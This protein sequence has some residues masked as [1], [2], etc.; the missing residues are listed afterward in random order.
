[1][2][3][4]KNQYLLNY[5]KNV[6]SQFGE[7]GIIEQIFSTIGIKHGICCEFG[8][9]DGRHLSNTYNL[10]ANKG[11]SAVLIEGNKSR[12]P[13][14]QKTFEE[15]PKVVAVNKYVGFSG[16]DLLDNILSSHNVPKNIDFLSIDIDG[17]D[18]HI[19]DS[20]Q[21]YTPK[22]VVIEFNPFIP[23]DVEFVQKRDPNVQHGTSILSM[24]KLAL[25]KGY[26]LICINQENAFYVQKKYFGRFKI[27]DNSIQE[28]KHYKE[29]LKVFQLYDG[30]LVFQGAQYL[31]YY[32]F[33]YDFN[34][35]FQVLPEVIRRDNLPWGG[36]GITS[37][38]LY[39]VLK[40]LKMRHDEKPED[41]WAWKT[42]YDNFNTR[43]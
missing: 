4:S 43:I 12:F 11:W 6:E 30:T 15:N 5:R 36:R 21:L 33:A 23:A 32:N 20:L 29:P 1:M 14:L 17:N 42:V 7:D 25:K 9:W 34:K 37:K 16:D 18:Y 24:T 41:C 13:Q 19:W 27:K 35:H 39:K 8:A 40:F 26:Q 31:Y 22:V 2:A 38:I 3:L 28:L 10:I